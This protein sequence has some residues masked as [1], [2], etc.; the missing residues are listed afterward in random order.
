LK[1]SIRWNGKI[2]AAGI[3]GDRPACLMRSI[4]R[5]TAIRPTCSSTS[6][7]ARDADR[8]ITITVSLVFPKSRGE[9]ALRSADPLARR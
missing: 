6:G 3:D 7:A 2:G 4:P 9:I 5:T 8:F 1:L